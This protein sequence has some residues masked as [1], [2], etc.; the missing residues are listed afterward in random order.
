M[1]YSLSSLALKGK[2]Y[3]KLHESKE[4]HALIKNLGAHFK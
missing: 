4:L 2:G 3:L 1:P